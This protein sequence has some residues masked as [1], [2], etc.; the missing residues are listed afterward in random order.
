MAL[1]STDT[2]R[3]PVHTGRGWRCRQPTS[4]SL[5]GTTRNG[6]HPLSTATKPPTT[7]ATKIGAWAVL[8]GG[9]A[10]GMLGITLVGHLGFN[11]IPRYRLDAYLGAVLLVL[12]V[13]GG[14]GA[15]YAVLC[16]RAACNSRSASRRQV[17]D[18]LEPPDRSA[19]HTY[20]A[21]AVQGETISFPAG[22]HRGDT[23]ARPV[24]RQATE[25]E[26]ARLQGYAE[27]YVDGIA[28]REEGTTA[29]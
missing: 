13:D 17:L 10:L 15:R 25:V 9:T 5:A 19:G 24:V 4:P 6:G 20:Q 22:M 12:A 16:I 21:R 3:E 11:G 14:L 23:L 18:D 26:E 28:R 29:N 8:A 27:G 7:T 2:P 1:T